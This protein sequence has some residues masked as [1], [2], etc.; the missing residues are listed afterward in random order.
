VDSLFI[1]CLTGLACLCYC[2]LLAALAP[3]AVRCY[4]PRHTPAASWHRGCGCCLHSHLPAAQ[5]VGQ[6][7]T[8]PGLH[9]RPHFCVYCTWRRRRAPSPAAALPATHAR[10]NQ[11][12]STAR[13]TVLVRCVQPL[14][15]DHHHQTVR[16]LGDHSVSTDLLRPTECQ[17][18]PCH[19]ARRRDGS[20]AQQVHSAWFILCPLLG[21]TSRAG[22]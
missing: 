8:A 19:H 18:V 22:S 13:H 14:W 2:C 15:M 5:T 1:T 7:V 17:L 4:C 20:W 16:Q 12:A 9:L 21:A 6:P 10:G 11:C 3:A